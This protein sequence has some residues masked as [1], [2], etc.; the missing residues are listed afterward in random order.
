MLLALG[1]LSARALAW[2]DR[3]HRIIAAAAE[4]RLSTRARKG[5]ADLL[6]GRSLESEANWAD[7]IGKGQG[8]GRGESNSHFVRIP[9][10]S[11]DYDPGRDCRGGDCLIESLVKYIN[12]LSDPKQ[13]RVRRAD[14]L[15][16][17]VHLI[18]DIHQPLHCT[19][20]GKDG[21]GNFQVKFFERST[22][23][24]QVWDSNILDKVFSDYKDLTIAYYA[25][26]VNETADR[27]RY[28]TRGT[29]VD[30]ALESHR[31]ARAAYETGDGNLR[32]AYHDR[33]K[34]VVDGQLAKASVRL[35]KVLN[36]IFDG[37]WRGTV[38]D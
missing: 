6:G 12:V 3:G 15:K 10:E 9:W 33:S 5:V 4:E 28:S 8:Q 18:G 37:Q 32:E 31:L 13:P 1:P 20:K 19:E 24:H 27:S 35:A 16:Y 36:D 34:Q 7:L 17:V 30:W 11:N 25:R 26:H 2:G 38:K 22:N 21:G 29:V 14:A 23:L